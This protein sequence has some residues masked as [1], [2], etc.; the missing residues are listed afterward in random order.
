MKTI[1]NREKYD[2]EIYVFKKEQVLKDNKKLNKK[3]IIIIIL[4]II[5]ILFIIAFLSVYLIKYKDYLK[6]LFDKDKKIQNSLQTEEIEL[7][8]NLTQKLIEQ[9]TEKP[10]EQ[11]TERLTEKQIEQPTEKTNRTIIL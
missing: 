10:T 4:I 11:P 1:T 8:E 6:K 9:P 7:I 5:F 2:N 3:K